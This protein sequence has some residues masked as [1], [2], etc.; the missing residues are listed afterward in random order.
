[1]PIDYKNL[2][3]EEYFR[4]EEASEERHEFLDGELFLMTGASE[5]HSIICANLS[6]LFTQ[7]LKAS[8]CRTHSQGMRL[9]VHAANCFYYPDVMVSCESVDPKAR[10]KS[11][12]L[13][14]AEVLSPSTEAID[15]RE[16]LINYRKL[17][18][19]RFYLLINQDQQ[20]IKLYKKTAGGIWDLEV[21]GAG[22]ELILKLLPDSTFSAALSDIY[23]GIP[24][25]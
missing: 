10:Y 7:H 15:K 9:W 12:A 11:A 21:L 13:L 1:M 19:L 14:V 23:D 17:D 18:S 5:A 20:Q 8:P 6:G 25:G 2:T 16:K 24:I 4:V 22:D 3:V